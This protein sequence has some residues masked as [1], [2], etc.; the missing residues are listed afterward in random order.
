MIQSAWRLHAVVT[1]AGRGVGAALALRLAGR[2]ARVVLAARSADELERATQA[3]RERHGAGCAL[4]VRCDVSD[5]RDVEALSLRAT[6]FFDGAP[7]DLLV[8]NAGIAPRSPLL[9]MS[10]ETWDRV[11][12]V[13][14]KGAFLCTKAFL[15]AM[16]ARKKGRVVNV[17]SI[18]ST[19]GTP[20]LS[21]YC[22]SKWGLVGFTKAVAEEVREHGVQVLSVMP[23]SIDTKMLE[24]SGFAPQ[25]S[26]D[27]VAKT[28]EWLGLDCPDA[29]T[30][31]A[32][33]MFG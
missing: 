27:D 6:E 29:M 16:V 23:G 8:N 1:G 31:S 26:A 14:L 4:G 17:A 2:G 24:G 11:L 30:A 19:L 28:I 33:E 18:S 13:N 22:A 20:K 21:A 5:A 10:E 9:E 12:D 7:A 15:P 32:V 3:V 25:M